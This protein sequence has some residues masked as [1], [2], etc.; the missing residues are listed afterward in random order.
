MPSPRSSSRLAR[1]RG[2]A[3]RSS[4]SCSLA[5]SSGS[6]RPRW[7][8]SSSSRAPT[9]SSSH[10]TRCH[11][12]RVV[13]CPDWQR[14]PGASL[15]CGLAALDDDVEAAVVVLADGPDL[16][17][18]RSSA[19]STT[20]ARTDGIVAA[21]YAGARGHPLVL[22]RADWDDDPGRGPARPPG[23]ARPVRRPRR[24]RRRRH[25]GGPG[26]ALGGRV[27]PAELGEL[28]HE[29]RWHPLERAR[30]HVPAQALL[31]AVAAPAVVAAGEVRLGLVPLGVRERAIEEVLEE[32]LAALARIAL[33]RAPPRRGAASGRGDRGGVET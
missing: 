1:R 29:A 22:G 33:T 18:P 13:P 8:R 27:E 17:P 6:A 31:E 20:G 9:S 10:V 24:A 7:T 5:C 25:A 32:L 11:S 14:G 30:P 15:R 3:A 4:G 2:S 28:V 23:A 19:S 12:A 16:S 21:S 26:A